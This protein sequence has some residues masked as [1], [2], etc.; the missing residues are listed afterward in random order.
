MSTDSDCRPLFVYIPTYNRPDSL[1]RQLA[2][3]SAQ[4]PDWPGGMRVLVSDN[5]SSAISPDDLAA[6]SSEFDVDV[7]RNVGNI[8]GNANIALGFVFAREDEYLWILSD[9]DTV[10]PTALSYLA[11][12]GRVGDPDAIVLTTQSS[13]PSDFVHEWTRAWDDVHENGLISNVI[14]RSSVF[15]DQAALAFYYHNTSF[16]H[17]CVLLGTLKERSSLRYRVLPSAEIFAPAGDH[18]EQAGDYSLSYAGMP[19]LLPLLPRRQARKFARLW[20]REQGLEFFNRRTVL[21]GIHLSSKAH[22]KKYGGIRARLL[23]FAL[24]I[25]SVTLGRLVAPL[26]RLAR[27]LLPE[28]FKRAIRSRRS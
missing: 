12:Q 20:L 6:V 9:N 5:C 23:L 1:R 22:L 4:R 7:R 28:R 24:E 14:Y 8:G 16:P 2:S 25:W 19:Q 18:G 15:S 3:L 13:A 11:S 10:A 17:L 26:E 27:R 21:P